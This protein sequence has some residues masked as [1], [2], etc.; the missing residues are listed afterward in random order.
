MINSCDCNELMINC[1]IAVDDELV[2]DS[3]GACAN[4]HWHE[5]VS[6]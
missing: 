3:A 2:S 4:C 5:H 1:V 6:K